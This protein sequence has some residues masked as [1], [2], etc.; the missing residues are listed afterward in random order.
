MRSSGK[1]FLISFSALFFFCAEA[2]SKSSLVLGD[3]RTDKYL[4]LLEG[5]KVAVFSNHTGIIGD[6]SEGLAVPGKSRVTEKNCTV[7]FGTPAKDGKVKYGPHLLD[8]L[9]GEGIDVKMVFCPEHGFRGTQDA[10]AEVLSGIDP[11]T[12]IPVLS[13]YGKREWKLPDKISEIDVLVVDIQDVGLRYYTYYIAMLTLM[14]ECGAQGKDFIILDRPNPNGFYAD[15]PVLRKDLY[16]GVGRL[17]I[18]TVHSLTLGELACM[19]KGENWIK[20][21]DNL[22]LT[23]IKCQGYKHSDKYCLLKSPSPNLKDMKAVYLYASTCYFEGTAISL[24]RGTP[25]PFEIYGSPLSTGDYC[26]TPQSMAGA[27]KPMYQGIEC[28]G[29]S[30]REKPLS[31]IL[32]EGINLDYITDAYADYPDKSGFFISSGRFFCLL[33]GDPAVMDMVKTGHSGQ[34]IKYSPFWTDALKN[35]LEIRDKY[36]LYEL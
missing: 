26:F 6:R 8:F 11:Q 9:L 13:L 4:P 33:M 10:G 31:E 7:A 22:A 34:E 12:G 21:A 20:N 19:A 25:Y 17:P 27:L 36:L 32:K 28:H 1:I 5:R 3:E 29:R 15:G 23:I 14:E 16:S 30:L 2:F 35:Y 18:S 24:G